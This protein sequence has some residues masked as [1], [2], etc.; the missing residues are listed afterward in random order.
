MDECE[1]N[2]IREQRNEELALRLRQADRIHD[3]EARLAAAEKLLNEACDEL[4]NHW[5]SADGSY[6]NEDVINLTEKIDA[7]FRG[8]EPLKVAS[9]D[10]SG[11]ES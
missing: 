5:F 8:D 1:A 4:H 10:N 2:V 9:S 7:Y 3:L 11:G 6:N